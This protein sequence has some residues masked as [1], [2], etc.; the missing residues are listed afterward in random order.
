MVLWGVCV[1]V[2]VC[3]CVDVCVCVGWG[4][5]EMTNVF[6][7]YQ[8]IP[9]LPVSLPSCSSSKLMNDGKYKVR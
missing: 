7:N 2:C 8:S 1:C 3:V 4:C 5:G 6:L 9:T